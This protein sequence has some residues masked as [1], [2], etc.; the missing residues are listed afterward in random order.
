[1]GRAD[2][3]VER[4]NGRRRSVMADMTYLSSGSAPTA[5]AGDLVRDADGCCPPA[6]QHPCIIVAGDPRSARY[7][8]IMTA[9]GSGSEAALHAYCSA[10]NLL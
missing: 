9:M 7:Q 1:M 8:R 4:R 6:V 10:R 2:G 5:P 3:R